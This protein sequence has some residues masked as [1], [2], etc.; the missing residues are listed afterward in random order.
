MNPLSRHIVGRLDEAEVVV[1]LKGSTAEDRCEYV[2]PLGPDVELEVSFKAVCA[3][4]LPADLER[5]FHRRRP[6]VLEVLR[7]IEEMYAWIAE[8]DSIIE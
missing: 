3:E 4:S 1:D 6:E 2:I 7:A 8:G 5:S